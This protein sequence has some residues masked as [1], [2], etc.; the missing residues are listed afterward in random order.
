MTNYGCKFF[1]LV[2]CVHGRGIGGGV[3][4]VALGKLEVKFA[5]C[6][7]KGMLK[8]LKIEY[9]FFKPCIVLMV[10]YGLIH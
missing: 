5:T 7:M 9:R 6:Y 10:C 8:S 4:M 1:F 3:V 2:G